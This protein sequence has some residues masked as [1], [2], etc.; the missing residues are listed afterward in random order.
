[1]IF[2]YVRNPF[3][4]VFLYCD[5]CIRSLYVIIYRRRGGN[6]MGLD[7]EIKSIFNSREIDIP[8]GAKLYFKLAQKFD[9]QQ[10]RAKE[11]IKSLHCSK[12]EDA[13][14]VFEYIKEELKER[15][16]TCSECSLCK[17]EHHTQ[18]VPG[19]GELK[20]PL[21][22]IGEGP[23]FDEDRIGRPFVGRAGQLLTTILSKLG[24]KREKIYTTNVIKCRPPMNRKPLAE[25]IKACSDILETE[26]TYLS[27]SVII[28]LGSVPLNYFRHGISITKCRG[29]WIYTRGF[30]VMPTFHPA[31][32][33]RQS[34]KALY[35]TKWDVWLDFNEAIRKVNEMR[36]EY[37]FS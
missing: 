11:F 32:I 4:W 18:K 22:I 9:I 29:Q 35:K 13:G 2:T 26:L 5:I 16:I 24:I 10:V 23:G 28:T 6:V 20:S 21:M 19:E 33:L 14:S 12:S 36:P 30:W 27:P 34:G 31:Y 3:L 8:F 25:E 17:A 37:N 15:L 7:D 1:M